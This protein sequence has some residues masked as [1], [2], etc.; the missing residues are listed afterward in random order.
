[1]PHLYERSGSRLRKWGCIVDKS[2]R[3]YYFDSHLRS[4][5][6]YVISEQQRADGRFE[7]ILSQSA[8]YP[9]SGGQPH[10]TGMLNDIPVVDVFIREDEV[11]HVVEHSLPVGTS[12]VGE[13]DWQ[14]RLD[15]MQHHCGQHILSAAFEQLFD[16]D[17]V[18]F[19]MSDDAVTVDI[20]TPVLSEGDLARAEQLANCMIMENRPVSAQFVQTSELS[21]FALRYP[22]KVT[23]DIR[24]VTIADFNDNACGGTHPKFTGEIGLLKVVQQEKVRNAT[25]LMFVCGMRALRDYTERVRV[26]QALTSHLST[27]WLDLPSVV[28]AQIAEKAEL[29]RTTTRLQTALATYRV[30]TEVEAGMKD[31]LEHHFIVARFVDCADMAECKALFQ[32]LQKAVSRLVEDATVVFVGQVKDRVYV[33]GESSGLVNMQQLVT[34][35]LAS[36][37]GKGGGKPTSAQG[38]ALISPDDDIGVHA[39]RIREMIFASMRA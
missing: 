27:D 18:G 20:A 15:H 11:I 13:I 25:R 17:T 21:Q 12:V 24:I 3:L 14:R 5:S 30:E 36:V 38:S 7:I 4:F 10:D 19:H 26:T 35:Y 9:T 28:K 22:P 32:A 23:Q 39:A 2:R 8:F 16:L 37:G 34:T 31:I 29:R 6:A 33:Q 1:M